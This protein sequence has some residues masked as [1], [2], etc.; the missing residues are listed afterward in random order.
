MWLADFRRTIQKCTMVISK[1]ELNNKKTFRKKHC[2]Y[3]VLTRVVE[4]GQMQTK[5]QSL[6]Q[7]TV[8]TTW[9]FNP[10]LPSLHS[11]SSNCQFW[12]NNK[13]LDRGPSSVQIIW[14]LWFFLPAKNQD[15]RE[16]AP[17]NWRST[18]II[19]SILDYNAD[20]DGQLH[21]QK[22]WMCRIKVKS[23]ASR[24]DWSR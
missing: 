15:L 22:N 11:I 21:Q 18:L 2:L 8:K 24:W 23:H 5:L 10:R 6:Y 3:W 16:K 19:M 9:M 1:I 17:G 20:Y 13:E 14:R 4:S 12:G 7:S